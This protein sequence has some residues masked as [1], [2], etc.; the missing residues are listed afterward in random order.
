MVESL[1]P[2][3]LALCSQFSSAGI[4]FG[5]GDVTGEIYGVTGGEGKTIN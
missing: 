4:T 1:E 5:D 2:E 3:A